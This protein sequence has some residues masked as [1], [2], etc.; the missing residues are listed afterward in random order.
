[1]SSKLGEW[2]SSESSAARNCI[3]SSLSRY[4]PG[5]EERA[6]DKRAGE[7]HQEY[8]VKARSV[9]QRF[10]QVPPGTIGPVEAKLLSFERVQ[11][12]VFGAFGEVSEPVHR[13]IDHLATS[14][15]TVAGP[16]RS[17]KGLERS[18]EGERTLV[19]GMLRRKLSVAGVRAQCSSLL[20]RLEM[21]GP[22]M[23]HAA[24]R[25]A[26]ALHQEQLLAKELLAHTQALRQ[27]RNVLRRG[28]A[29]TF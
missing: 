9:D 24:A 11:G 10:G 29:N 1:M 28:F 25:R 7:L 20:G 21:L 8:I 23:G 13:L 16:Q 17:R 19:V 26:Q 22:G 14:R 27:E 3:S 2:G 6:V 4:K 12:V 15:V 5:A 18:S